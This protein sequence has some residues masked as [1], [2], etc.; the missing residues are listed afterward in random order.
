MQRPTSGLL[1]ALLLSCA[2]WMLPGCSKNEVHNSEAVIERAK[3]LCAC[4]T[5]AC[6]DGLTEEISAH[7]RKVSETFPRKSDVPPELQAAIRES[8]A[9]TLKCM[10]RLDRLTGHPVTEPTGR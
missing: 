6:V 7:S 5:K 2:I 9:I 4:D 1:P 3:A 8:R 10:P